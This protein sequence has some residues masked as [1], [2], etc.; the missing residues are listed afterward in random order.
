MESRGVVKRKYF[1][2]EE[3]AE[4]VKAFISGRW[5]CSELAGQYRIHPALIYKW[6]KEMERQGV[7][8]KTNIGIY[9]FLSLGG[10]GSLP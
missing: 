2:I 7:K 5:S 6:R 3:K 10:F 4:I 9:L 8:N 1:R